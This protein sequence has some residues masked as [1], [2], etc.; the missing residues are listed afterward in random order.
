MVNLH[1][2]TLDWTSAGTPLA[3][4]DGLTRRVF[5]ALAGSALALAAG[6]VVTAGV[7]GSATPQGTTVSFG[8]L[9]IRAAELQA[10][11]GTAG[12]DA[13]GDGAAQMSNTAGHGTHGTTSIGGTAQPANFTWGSHLVLTLDIWNETAQALRITPGQL[14][15]RIGVEGPSIT[16]R[17]SGGE[18]GPLEAGGR[19]RMWMSFLVP[20]DARGFIAEFADPWKDSAPIRLALPTVYRRPGRME[21]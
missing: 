3:G 20:T 14:R 1:Q 8:H 5:G 12:D 7:T 9:R 6:A 21:D 13:V 10:R 15:I 17:A 4:P 19:A 16:N 18:T 11:L 2:S